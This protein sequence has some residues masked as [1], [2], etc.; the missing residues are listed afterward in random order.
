MLYL[1]ENKKA[2]EAEVLEQVRD[3][4]P[5]DAGNPT[6]K[7]TRDKKDGRAGE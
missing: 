1:G 2:T 3:W 7:K 6:P 4:N 5:G